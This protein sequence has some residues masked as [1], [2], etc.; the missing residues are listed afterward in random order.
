LADPAY[1][2]FQYADDEKL[3][4]RIETHERYSENPVPF[5][6][7]VLSHVGTRPGQRLLD[8]GSGSGQY[9]DKL[10]GL[11]VIAVDTSPGM[12]AKVKVPA[13]LADAQGLPFGARSFDRVMANHVI[14]H[15]PDMRLA[16]SELRRVARPGG[17]VVMAANSR[18]SMRPLF[19]LTDEA[20]AEAG[21]AGYPS[22]GLRFALEDLPLVREIFPNARAEFYDDA[23]RFASPEP[24]LA[25]VRSMWVDLLD[26]ERRT[27]FLAG[28]ERRVRAIVERDGVF[29]V[30]K[31]SGC[32]V[33]ET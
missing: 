28:L 5:T 30:P 10:R 3:R 22:V 11:R 9:H 25:Y 14:Y 4:I 27:A 2:R 33:A 24:V 17:R 19:A 1:V 18:T 7:W 15:V 13:V 31:R 23:F 8:V 21:I 12:L 26:R 6:T 29:R 32:F 20:A 16:M